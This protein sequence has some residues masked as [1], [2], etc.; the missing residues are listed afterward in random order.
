MLSL[1]IG[2]VNNDTINQ[3][4]FSIEQPSSPSGGTWIKFK[5]KFPTDNIISDHI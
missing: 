4:P 2:K 1:L 5:K 3:T